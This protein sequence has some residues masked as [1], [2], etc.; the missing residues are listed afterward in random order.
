MCATC[1]FFQHLLA[2][3]RE[4][5]QRAVG[6]LY[7][8]ELQLQPDALLG[9]CL[10]DRVLSA[11]VLTSVAAS[12]EH[13][14]S[15]TWHHMS[16]PM[17]S[18]PACRSQAHNT[19]APGRTWPGLP[20]S[21][22]D[23]TARS[24]QLSARQGPCEWRGCAVLLCARMCSVATPASAN[25]KKQQPVSTMRHSYAG[26]LAV[27]CGR[28]GVRSMASRPC[29]DASHLSR[30][31]T[32]TRRLAGRGLE[33]HCWSHFGAWPLTNPC[34]SAPTDGCSRFFSPTPL[35]EL[36]QSL[37][38]FADCLSGASG[39]AVF[40]CPDSHRGEASAAR[41]TTQA[42]T[43]R[44]TVRAP[45]W[46]DSDSSCL[47][48]EPAPPAFAAASPG[49]SGRTTLPRDSLHGILALAARLLQCTHVFI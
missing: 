38:L 2:A 19:K 10:R 49:L 29:D 37:H 27:G 17:S 34:R 47:R 11:A 18:A 46:I 33:L 24:S 26:N 8:E 16:T 3:A 22:G 25:T 21:S 30:M 48:V 39:G 42:H 20:Q 7:C 28:F 40:A 1:P 41:A 35:T 9:V 45:C 32:S 14:L 13:H 6:L 44:K 43:R 12:C 23:C 36:T 5:L 31:M 15:Q 4:L